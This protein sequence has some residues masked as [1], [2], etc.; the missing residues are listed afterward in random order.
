MSVTANL[1]PDG[2][3]Q[4]HC[5]RPGCAA[6][7]RVQPRG[8][9]TW[10][11][12]SAAGCGHR[13]LLDVPELVAAAPPL[14]DRDDR[15]RRR[16]RPEAGGNGLVAALVA[17]AAI[18][19]LLVGGALVF[20]IV[21]FLRDKAATPPNAGEVAQTPAPVLAPP[22]VPPARPKL[23]ADP[24][25]EEVEPAPAAPVEE[26][27]GPRPVAAP[28]KTGPARA[29]FARGPD[30]M[31]KD[32]LDAVKKSTALI[33]RKDGGSGSGFVIRSGL[34]MTNFHVIS[35][36]SLDELSVRFVSLDDTAPPALK[37]TLLYCHPERDRAILKVE[38]DR[39]PLEFC[40]PDTKL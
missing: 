22:E 10:V 2:S 6:V 3:A 19:V 11:T 1:A 30:A 40:P 21:W 14:R 17:G 5:P 29:P 23:P 9:R 7:L 18:V 31:A 24:P 4:V 27:A 33:E 37:P 38:T 13:F 32:A 35:G 25:R 26:P 28:P 16:L 34:V 15:P 36:S 20:G 39:P 12:C 8:P